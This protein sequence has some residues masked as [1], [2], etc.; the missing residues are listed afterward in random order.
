MINKIALAGCGNVGTALL[1]ILHEKKDEL[2][3]KYGFEY[4]VVLVSDLT[5]GVVANADGI[6]LAAK[7][8]NPAKKRGEHPLN[9][10][11]ILQR[12]IEA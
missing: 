2:K 3:E 1:E 7:R 11:T 10:L 9:P 6:D 12:M 5:K 4:K 8:L